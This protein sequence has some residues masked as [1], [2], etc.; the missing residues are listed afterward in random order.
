MKEFLN[1]LVDMHVHGTP[2]A[3]PRIETWNY[4]KEM[5]E[6]GYRAVGFKEHFIP[7]TGAAY[8][9]N[10]SPSRFHVEVAG[11]LVLN[12]ACGG[13]NVMAVASACAMG[14]KMIYFPTVSAKNHCEYL[15][16]VASFGGGSLDVAERPI[17]VTDG[18]GR[19][20]EDA[21]AVVEYLKKRPGLALSMGHLSPAEIDVLLPFAL[22]AGIEKVVVDH[23]YF[24]IGASVS[25]VESW[26]KQGAYINFTCS[27]LEGNGKN[28]H[29][30][31]AV[32]DRTLELVPE[33]KLVISTD[34]GQPYNGSPVTGMM[35]MLE[36]LAV[37]L[38]VPEQRIMDM[39]HRIPAYLLDLDGE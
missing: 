12:N 34:Y 5:D 17:Q 22:S 14:A 7:T 10:H 1:G 35:K 3:A 24:I 16:T 27:S 38:K 4:L 32:L 36:T 21:A 18:R 15:K 30:P 26:A 2:S 8:L 23:P 13:L 28:G 9:F 29:V 25:Q 37:D 11:S 19:L 20:K 6:A 39:T 33:D 31:L